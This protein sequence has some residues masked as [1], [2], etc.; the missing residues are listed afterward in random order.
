MDKLKAIGKEMNSQDNRS[1]QFVMFAVR[2]RKLVEATDD[3]DVLEFLDED[4]SEIDDPCEDCKDDYFGGRVD[5]EACVNCGCAHV[6]PMSKEWEFDLK[7]GLFFTAKA[8]E[9][10][11]AENH[12]HY[13]KEVHSYGVSSWRNPEMQTVL[14]FLSELPDGKARGHYK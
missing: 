2:D 8:C 9:Q 7:C 12:Y 5:Q 6:I 14:R 10:H 4:Y 1:T 13:T 11:I 3:Y